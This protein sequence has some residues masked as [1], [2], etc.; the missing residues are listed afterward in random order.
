VPPEKWWK[1]P[2]AAPDDSAGDD[3][4][5]QAATAEAAKTAAVTASGNPSWV[6][7]EPAPTSRPR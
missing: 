4:I 3:I 2:V 1:V 7:G 6:A 5:I